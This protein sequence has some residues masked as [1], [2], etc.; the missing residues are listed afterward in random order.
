MLVLEKADVISRL[1]YL[2]IND[3]FKWDDF[4][5][6]V[7]FNVCFYLYYTVSVKRTEKQSPASVYFIIF[8]Y[9]CQVCIKKCILKFLVWR[10]KSKNYLLS[11]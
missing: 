6:L 5:Q 3:S 10:L 8:H 7:R 2:F 9:F 4:I 11:K 1:L